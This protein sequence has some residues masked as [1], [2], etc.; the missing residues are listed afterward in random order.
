[1]SDFSGNAGV[2]AYFTYLKPVKKFAAPRSFTGLKA[3]VYHKIGMV[4]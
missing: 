3:N 4:F 1:L 2:P